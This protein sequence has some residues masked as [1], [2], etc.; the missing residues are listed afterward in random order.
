MISFL[1]GILVG[2]GSTMYMNPVLLQ[3]VGEKHYRVS[4]LTLTGKVEYSLFIKKM[5]APKN[6][7][8]AYIDDCKRD[9]TDLVRPYVN[10]RYKLVLPC[11]AVFGFE[12]IT[13]NSIGKTRTFSG[14]EPI[15]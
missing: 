1:L 12:T 3:K 7:A 6:P 11:P 4:L 8:C 2:V 14:N 9:V 5:L 13:Y 15:I 10:P